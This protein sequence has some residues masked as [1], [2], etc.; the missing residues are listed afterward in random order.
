ME[1]G[2]HIWYGVKDEWTAMES[3]E[4][5]PSV[6]CVAGQRNLRSGRAMPECDQMSKDN[7][8]GSKRRDRMRKSGKSGNVRVGM[9]VMW[10]NGTEARRGRAR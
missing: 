7:G 10:L 9:A 5:R 4:E 1:G 3:G 8:P 2:S 6:A